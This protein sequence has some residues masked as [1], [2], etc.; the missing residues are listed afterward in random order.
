[1]TEYGGESTYITND[2]DKS[3]RFFYNSLLSEFTKIQYKQH[4]EKYLK[5]FGHTDCGQLL[6][7]GRKEL[8]NELIEFII[9]CR[10]KDMKHSAIMNYVKPISS[11]C[12]AND[13]MLNHRRIGG[14]IPR[15]IRN[16]RTF[17]YSR[18]Q[19]N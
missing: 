5:T 10:E 7:K 19:I 13:M 3:E 18:S 9:S 11:F 16:K 1:M 15:E 12:K 8:E 14:F 6:A 17:A 4:F 2:I